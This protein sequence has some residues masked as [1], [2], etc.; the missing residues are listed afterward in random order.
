MVGEKKK[1]NPTDAKAIGDIWIR[2]Q[3]VRTKQRKIRTPHGTDKKKIHNIL[4][5]VK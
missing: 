3:S 5:P 2:I 1:K 4:Q